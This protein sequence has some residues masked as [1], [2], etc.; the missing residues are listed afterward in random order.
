MHFVLILKS[1]CLDPL[2]FVPGAIKLGAASPNKDLS[3]QATAL[4]SLLVNQG[5]NLFYSSTFRIRG[6]KT[7]NIRI[8]IAASFLLLWAVLLFTGCPSHV[9]IANIN[10]DPGR[11][12]GK[13]VTVAGHVNDSYG[14]LGSGVFE[15]DDGTGTMWVYSSGFGMPSNG[16]K[17]A[18]TGRV[19]Q[20]FSFA[21]RSFATIVK[22][23]KARH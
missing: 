14:A 11:Y 6:A 15:I 17:V 10:R 1:F 5:A 12:A 13:E 18:V 7:L 19:A 16:T 21:G 20:G 9:S 4:C 3:I 23:T 8:R 2:R 22:E